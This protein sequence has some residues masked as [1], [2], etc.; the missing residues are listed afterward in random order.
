MRPIGHVDAFAFSP[1]QRGLWG[2][3][4]RWASFVA[5]GCVLESSRNGRPLPI[6]LVAIAFRSA[7]PWPRTG[8]VRRFPLRHRLWILH[9]S[10]ARRCG[11]QVLYMSDC[12][13][14]EL[15]S[16]SPD[17]GGSIEA[18]MTHLIEGFCHKFLPQ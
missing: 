7:V 17:I 1:F 15:A 6:A 3:L 2:W 12:I 11:C 4:G 8:L 5:L 16:C 13:D 18:N 10:S 9:V 14:R